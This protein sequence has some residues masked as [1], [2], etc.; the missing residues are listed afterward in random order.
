MRRTAVIVLRRCSR[1]NCSSSSAGA[2]ASSMI[3][4]STPSHRLRRFNDALDRGQVLLMVDVPR[5][6][7]TEIEEMLA[8]SHPEAH[9]EGEEPN[10]PAFP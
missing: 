1:A 4:I 10:I 8:T 2:W 5:S 9:F 6:R 3:G 7:V